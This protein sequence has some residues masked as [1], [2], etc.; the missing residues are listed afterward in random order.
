MELNHKE[1][2]GRNSNTWRLRTIL[3]R[4]DSINQEMK[5]QFKQFME[6]NKNENTTIQNLW[7]TAKA[8]LR[9][10]YIAIQGSLKRR[11]KSKM[12]FLY[13]HIKKLEL[14][15]KNRPN[16][17]TRRQLIKIRAET[18]ELETRSTVEQINRSRSSFSERINKIDKPLARLVQNYRERTQ[19]NK[20]MNE[21]GEVTTNTNEI[22]RIIRNF[23]QQLYA[24]KLNNLKELDAFLETYKLP[25]LKQEEIDLFKQTE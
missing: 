1:K 7:D 20:I 16:P 22:R 10:K 8:V 4:N 15:Q 9:G 11:E 19:I 24:N 6:T 14:E 23:Y 3:L 21:R 13:S 5:N 2:I 25:R 12:Q 18:N 17:H